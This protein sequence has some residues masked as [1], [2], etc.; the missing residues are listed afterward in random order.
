MIGPPNAGRSSRRTSWATAPTGMP[1]ATIADRHG[2]LVIEDSCDVLDSCCAA[3][4]PAR[5][6]TSRS[7]ASPAVTRSPRPATAA[8]SRSTTTSGSTRRSC[9]AGGAVGRRRTSSAARR[10]TDD[11]FGTLA[12]GTPY[13]LIFVF[14]DIG[15]N[16]EPS[17]IMAAYGLVQLDKLAEFNARRRQNFAALDEVLRGPRGQGRAAARPREVE[18]PRGCATRSCSREGIDRTAIQRELDGARH[19]DAH[20]VDRQHPPPA[21][22]RR[23]RAPCAGRRVSERRS[24]DGP[25][26]VAPDATTAS[27]AT[28]SAYVIESLADVLAD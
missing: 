8:W 6:P 28:T 20:G 2:L 26:A 11:R 3:R 15:Y 27:P 1:S 16:F 19:R 9:A 21:R 14:D 10:A 12:D 5:A 22:L 13:D 7:R 24:R 23:H 25:G 4:A 18:E 17:E